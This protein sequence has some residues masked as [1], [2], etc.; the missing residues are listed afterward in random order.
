MLTYDAVSRSCMWELADYCN[1]FLP[2]PLRSRSRPFIYNERPRSCHVMR[3]KKFIPFP[4]ASLAAAPSLLNGCRF[5]SSLLHDPRLAKDPWLW[6]PMAMG[7]QVH[8]SPPW[9]WSTEEGKLASMEERA[10]E[11]SSRGRE[12]R[13]SQ[14]P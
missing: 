9:P 13:G 14:W 1:Q 7:T 4:F 2:S 11:A 6:V 5:P 3:Q 12:R 8:G 10:R